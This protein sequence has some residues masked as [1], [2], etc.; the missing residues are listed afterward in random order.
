M[1]VKC[2]SHSKVMARLAF[3][4]CMH[5]AEAQKAKIISGDEIIENCRQIS[6]SFK[7]TPDHQIQS[8]AMKLSVSMCSI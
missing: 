7:L 5:R 8:K 6:E 3:D 2:S 4:Q 1:V